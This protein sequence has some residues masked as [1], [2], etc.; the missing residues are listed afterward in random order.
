MQRRP[1]SFDHRLIDKEI[2]GMDLIDQAEPKR[3]ITDPAVIEA[4]VE[5]A[6]IIWS[7]FIHSKS[8]N[9]PGRKVRPFKIGFEPMMETLKLTQIPSEIALKAMDSF[10]L[11]VPGMA[12]EGVYYSL[13][14]PDSLK[15]HLD[16]RKQQALSV[17][18]EN[19][20]LREAARS[21]KLT[22]LETEAAEKE[23]RAKQRA[24]AQAEA[25]RNSSTWTEAHMAQ[26]EEKA[27]LRAVARE[28]AE[29]DRMAK[30]TEAQAF[31]QKAIEAL[32]ASAERGGGA[33]KKIL[34]ALKQTPRKTGELAELAQTLYKKRIL[35]AL[36]DHR[37][38]RSLTILELRFIT[39]IDEQLIR[40]IVRQLIDE[41]VVAHVDEK[42]NPYTEAATAYAYRKTS[43]AVK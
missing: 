18:E 41:G 19:S 9:R 20:K 24:E 32:K 28:Q 39:E 16:E 36:P 10:L 38:K 1:G 21:D 29:K 33:L 3:E 27:R 12:K 7:R 11:Q 26:A 23:Q 31:V 42:A 17:K 34:E 13:V 4:T 6:K 15:E 35:E 37:S 14:D 30:Q 2:A 8:I 43:N 5:Q 40:K 22:R 25:K